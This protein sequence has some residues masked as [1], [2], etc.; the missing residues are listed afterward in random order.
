MKSDERRQEIL[1][2]LK[3]EKAPISA[4]KLAEKFEVSRQVIV[5]DVALL[6]A[7]NISIMATPK[8]YVL[9]DIKTNDTSY[10]GTI[11]CKHDAEHTLDELNIIVDHGGEV[12]DV[13]VEHPVYGQ[14]IGCLNVASRYD[15]IHLVDNIT[16]QK[17]KPLSTLTDGI[18]VH[19]IKCRDK[20]TF[21]LIKNKLCEKGYLL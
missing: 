5:G 6:R 16:E 15:A 13:I 14:L 12:I 8:G 2:I 10:I 20:E 17:T 1:N 4:N 9:N 3:K 19:N 18:H 7:A 21:E 11:A